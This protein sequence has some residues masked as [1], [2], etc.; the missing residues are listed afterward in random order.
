MKRILKE[1][2]LLLQEKEEVEKLVKEG[3]LTCS[4]HPLLI[5][6]LD[7]IEKSMNKNFSKLFKKIDKIEKEE[8]KEEAKEEILSDEEKKKADDRKIWKERAIGA[9]FT[10]IILIIVYL[11]PL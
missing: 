6:Q 10:L 2:V 4:A 8:I 5:K 1:L 9:F 3:K 7:N 11:S